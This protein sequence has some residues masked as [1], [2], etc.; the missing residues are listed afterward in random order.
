MKGRASKSRRPRQISCKDHLGNEYPS[1]AAM[2]RAYGI[3]EIM[4]RY[5]TGKLGWDLEKALTTPATDTRLAGAVECEDHLGNRFP[6]KKDMCDY[7]RIPRH[8]FFGRI[9]AGWSLEKALTE[10][11]SHAT[12]PCRDIK[13]PEGRTYRNLDEMCEAYGISKSDYVTNVKNGCGLS[14]ALTIKNPVLTKRPRDH[15]GNEYPSI[16]KMLEAYGVSKSKFRGRLER[17]WTLKDI[18]ENPRDVSNSIKSK[19]QDGVEYETQKQMLAAKGVSFVTYKHRKK[20]GL[21]L[22]K[23]LQGSSLHLKPS[24]D[25]HG[26]KFACQQDMLEWWTA[27]TGSYHHLKDTGYPPEKCILGIKNRKMSLPANIRIIGIIGT[28][29]LAEYDGKEV[30][31]P[32]ESLHAM[33][34]IRRVDAWLKEND[35]VLRDGAR[36]SRKIGRF[37]LI[38]NPDGSE[39]MMASDALFMRIFF[40]ARRPQNETATN[41]VTDCVIT[42]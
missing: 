28:Y 33:I 36:I 42:P 22:G 7:W 27:R 25:H 29:Y 24:I 41:P 37:Y 8:V 39:V 23:C 18:L 6:S 14:Q 1:L 11:L 17:G 3:T 21:E 13:D 4:Y 20:L 5:R 10:K 16:N 30:L 19:D 38:R 9:R 31:M 35:S 34:R 12:A 32:D 40:S 15:L 2:F 26:R